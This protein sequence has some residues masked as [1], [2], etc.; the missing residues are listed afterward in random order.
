MFMDVEIFESIVFELLT[1]PETEVVIKRTIKA[2][3]CRNNLQFAAKKCSGSIL[4]TLPYFLQKYRL[5]RTP[6]TSS[7]V[8]IIWLAFCNQKHVSITKM[9]FRIHLRGVLKYR[10]WGFMGL[11]IWGCRLRSNWYVTLAIRSAHKNTICVRT[12]NQE[13]KGVV[14]DK[15]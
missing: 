3:I 15:Y 9:S 14:A 1:L 5:N 12:L 2:F 13:T 11:K 6:Q 7:N 8:D 4:D 10:K